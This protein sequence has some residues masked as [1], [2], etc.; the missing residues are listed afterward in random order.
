MN[1]EAP[2]NTGGH[3]LHFKN[4]VGHNR[5]RIEFNSIINYKEIP[6]IEGPLEIDNSIISRVDRYKMWTITF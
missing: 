5:G 2:Y 1:Q 4:D 3:L 6:N